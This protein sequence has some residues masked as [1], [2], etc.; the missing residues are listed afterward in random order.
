[1]KFGILYELRVFPPVTEQQAYHNVL[2]QIVL[3]EKMGFEYVWMVEHHFTAADSHSSAP[4]VFYGALSQRTSKIRIGHGVVLLPSPFN[5]PIRVAERVAALDIL[6]NGRVDFGTGRSSPYE[7]LG[8]D[9][10][11]ADT[12]PMWEESLSIIPK[13]W[14]NEV[15]PG[16]EGRYF[17]IPPR[18]V[19]PKPVQKP[20][21]P[22]WM[23]CA[24]PESFDVAASKGVG[25][26][27]FATGVPQ[28][29]TKHIRRYKDNVQSPTDQAGSFI[30]S[31]VA[32]FVQTMCGEDDKQTR[33]F[34]GEAYR[35]SFDRR[36]QIAGG[37]ALSTSEIPNAQYGQDLSDFYEQYAKQLDELG[38][39]YPDFL[40]Y[41]L[42]I[43][44]KGKDTRGLTEAYR[45][46]DVDKLVEDAIVVGGDPE[47]CIRGLKLYEESGVDQVLIQPDWGGIT[48]EQ[49]METYRLFGEYV[50]PH[51]R[52]RD[53]AA[54]TGARVAIAGD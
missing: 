22:I 30:N 42:E 52:A 51:F 24:Q 25:V 27:A 7:Q 49:I 1:L 2:E 12:R 13:M 31:E 17:K 36:S 26:L 21:P 4:E 44:R 15:F 28:R 16:H 5:H 8:F 35:K 50:I 53:A 47:S 37:G 23:A 32:A 10:D 38:R 43:G 45:R 33:A 18:M 19:V 29:L 46:L 3:A 40:K 34:I 6:S 11:P 20:H 39:P 14:T 48:H 9:I 41:Y 54:Q